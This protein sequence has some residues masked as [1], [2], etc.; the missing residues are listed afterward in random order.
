MFFPVPS[1]VSYAKQNSTV[2]KQ[3][4]GNLLPLTQR[5][6]SPLLQ[7]L[8]QPLYS[9]LLL[10]VGHADYRYVQFFRGQALL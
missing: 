2:R 8:L 4:S 6:T 5:S 9:L 1:L 3:T 7:L 10:V